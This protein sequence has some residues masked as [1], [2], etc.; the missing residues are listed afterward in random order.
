M[1]W[2]REDSTPELLLRQFTPQ[3]CSTMFPLKTSADQAEG[4]R[5]VLTDLRAAA[6]HPTEQREAKLIELDERLQELRD[7]VV[8]GHGLRLDGTILQVWFDVSAVHTTCKTH[9]KGEVKATLERRVAGREGASRQSAALMEGYQGKLD[10]YSLLAAMVERQVLAGLRSAAPLILPV[11]ISTHGEFCP[12]TVQLQEWLVGQ[13][14]ARLRLEGERDD[15]VE[16]DELTTA[17]RCELRAALLVATAKGTAEMLAVAGRPFSKGGAQRSG[18]WPGACAPAARTAGHGAVGSAISDSDNS[19]SDS[20]SDSG[21]GGDTAADSD[22]NSSI[23]LR[24]SGDSD[25]SSTLQANIGESDDSD[26]GAG[27]GSGPRGRSRRSA[28]PL[29]LAQ[30]RVGTRSSARLAQRR[31]TVPDPAYDSAPRPPP[32]LTS[33]EGTRSSAHLASR[34]GPPR[35]EPSC[36]PGLLTNLDNALSIL[37]R[38]HPCWLYDADSTSYCSSTSSSTCT[39]TCSSSTCSS[40]C[41]SSSSSSISGFSQEQQFPIVTSL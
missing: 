20:G 10:R 35:P 23:D 8:D 36:A 40:S 9:L 5:Q 33:E 1:T 13:Y 2:V 4:A 3:Q 41:S 11:V 16:E 25:T 31:P 22:D 7:S 21:S 12:G 28:A 26:S 32:A 27:G 6:T 19:G 15:G 29:A 17:F 14:R 18:A 24:G 37:R 39:S 38:Q 34:R 30:P